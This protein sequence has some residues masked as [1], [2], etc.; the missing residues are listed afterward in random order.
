MR[1]RFSSVDKA[2]IP[3]HINCKNMFTL[4]VSSDLLRIFSQGGGSMGGRTSTI[5]GECI[6]ELTE[7]NAEQDLE[8]YE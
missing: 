4:P 6:G 7:H 8:I 3:Q 5:S 2:I 1:I